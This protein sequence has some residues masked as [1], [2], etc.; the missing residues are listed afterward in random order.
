MLQDAVVASLIQFVLH[1]VQIPD[2]QLAKALPP[3]IHPIKEPPPCFMVGMIQRVAALSLTYHCTKTLL[4]EPMILNFD[5]SVQGT[6]FHC[7]IVQSLYALAHWSL[8]TLF[9]FLN[10]GFL[11]AILPYRP[12]SHS[13][14][15]SQWMS[16]HFFHGI[17]SVVQ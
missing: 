2:F 3:H 12:A 8:L 16:T 17:C 5:L 13:V 14:F 10:S 7:S 4:F 9:C 11:T 15:F 1:L 6:L